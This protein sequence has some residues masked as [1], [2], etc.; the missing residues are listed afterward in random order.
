MSQVRALGMEKISAR[1]PK[2]PFGTSKGRV[3][4]VEFLVIGFSESVG[5]T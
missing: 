2:A 4:L 1:R 5:F 3:G